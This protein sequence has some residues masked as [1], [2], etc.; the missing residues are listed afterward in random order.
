MEPVDGTA[1]RLYETCLLQFSGY[2]KNAIGEPP[3]R[4]KPD[5]TKFEGEGQN[6]A[7]AR[8][9]RG[10]P[11]GWPLHIRGSSTAEAKSGCHPGSP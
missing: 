3:G 1:A 8:G 10:T 4:I 7:A 9:P 5:P 11:W 6:Q 2:P